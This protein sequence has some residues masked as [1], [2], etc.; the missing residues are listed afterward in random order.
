MAPYQF[1][2]DTRIWSRPGYGGIT[3]NDG[4]E[5]EQRL[6]SIISAAQDRSVL[7]PE[8][9]PHC[10]DW[11][12]TYHLSGSRANILRPFEPHLKGKVLEIGAGCGAITRYMGECGADVLALEGTLRRATIARARTNDLENVTVLAESFSAFE[13]DEKFD[14]VTLIGV[15]EYASMFVQAERPDVAMLTRARQLLKPTGRLIIA[16]EN[17]LGLKYF[18]GAPE[19]HVGIPSFGLEDRYLPNGVRTYGRHAIDALLKSTGFSSNRFFAPFPD[20]KFPVSIVSE[21]GFESSEFD[22]SALA[23]Q[24]VRRDPQLPATLAFQPERTWQSL[25][26]NRIALDLSNSFL[27]S[28]HTEP[29]HVAESALAWHFSTER[30]ADLC[31][32]TQFLETDANQILVSAFRPRKNAKAQVSINGLSNRLEPSTQYVRGKTLSTE[33]LDIVTREGWTDETVASFIHRYVRALSEAIGTPIQAEHLFDETISGQFIDALP[34]N[35]M[36]REDG[37]FQLI[38]TE[39]AWDRSI[40]AAYLLFRGL[41]TFSLTLTRIGRHASRPI[42]THADFLHACYASIHCPI[43]SDRLAAFCLLEAELQHLVNILSQQP[44]YI[45][46]TLTQSKIGH[47]NAW[48][49]IDAERRQK[50]E[51]VTEFENLGKSTAPLDQIPSNGPS[52]TPRAA[53]IVGHT[54]ALVN[55]LRSQVNDRDALLQRILQSRSWKLTKPFRFFN[56]SLAALQH[57]A[58]GKNAIVQAA[59]M[60]RRFNHATA[61]PNKLFVCIH[62]YYPD[63]LPSLFE[64][65]KSLPLPTRILVTTMDEHQAIA[66]AHAKAF[67]LDVEILT[68]EN[69]GRD[70][71]P[72][73]VALGKAQPRDLVLKIHTKKSPHRAD[74]ETWRDDM[75]DKL[76]SPSMVERV[77]K[78]FGQS[79][80]LGLVAPEGHA[81]S[82][83][84]YM[85]QNRERFQT[86]LDRMPKSRLA[87]EANLFSG[88]AMFYARLGAMRP[89]L[90]MGLKPS[91][92]EA[93]A[94]QLDGTMAHTVE[95]LLGASVTAAGFYMATTA[96]P[97]SEAKESSSEFHP[98]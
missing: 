5:I 46:K 83:D 4:D 6:L 67:D 44:D 35:I 14:V 86:L 9:K 93:E 84:K 96:D 95:R 38:D 8:L 25:F 36:C 52:A 89:L 51:L 12:S 74:G 50:N 34:Q 59:K 31:K 39:W 56:R 21:K 72:F 7:S 16:I 77:F 65:L 68:V 80:D 1:N 53:A 54:H 20:Y 98:I 30:R 73:L 94:Q 42:A 13:T 55:E 71:L 70:I 10:T 40:S 64:R 24:S 90:A 41:H 47:A 88:G 29:A 28:A 58:L 48:E 97:A 63:L 79:A 91:E 17:Q 61:Q 85:G 3:Y 2:E 81:L 43:D 45:F 32:V 75:L 15:L 27:I 78:E 92:F 66:R 69:R 62:A 87:R 23:I 57:S 76:L 49:T 37:Q 60:K 22:A 11:A 82:I 33:L 26:E 19:D 18:A